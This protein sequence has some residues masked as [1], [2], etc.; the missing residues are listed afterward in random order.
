M[1]STN[2]PASCTINFI[3]RSKNC[4]MQLLG[5]RPAGS[6][7]QLPA[8]AMLALAI[9]HAGLANSAG[10]RP[11]P[12]SETFG[13]RGLLNR[14][15][16]HDTITRPT[17]TSSLH[18]SD[19]TEVLQPLAPPDSTA[20]LQRAIDMAP[21]GGTVVLDAGEI[22]ISAPLNLTRGSITV[23]GAEVSANVLM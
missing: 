17:K 20:A 22:Y 10:P 15:L 16:H 23:T 6:R 9:A 13:R 8:I 7:M 18:N 19:K 3:W 4:P 2:Q 12:L 11:V 1:H 21:V 5:G 14:S